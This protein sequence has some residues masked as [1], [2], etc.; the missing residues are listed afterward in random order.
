LSTTVRA[1]NKPAIH[2][3]ALANLASRD[4]PLFLERNVSELPLRAPESPEDL[5][6]CTAMTVINVMQVIR[7]KIT[8]INLSVSKEYQSFQTRKHIYNAQKEY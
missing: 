2:F 4:L 6:D 8:N 1:T 7:F 3:V 5:P